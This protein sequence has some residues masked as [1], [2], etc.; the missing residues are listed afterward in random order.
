MPTASLQDPA[1][2]L[3]ERASSSATIRNASVMQLPDGPLPPATRETRIATTAEPGAA[4]QAVIANFEHPATLRG[5]TTHFTV[6]YDPALGAA[7]QSL[8]DG[9][10]ARCE[11]D[12]T[13]LAAIFA[14]QVSHF[15]IILANNIG[16]GAYHDNCSASDLYCDASAGATSDS[17]NFLVVA[18]EVEV[19]Q[20]VQNKGWNCGWS[21]GEGLSRTLAT[22]LYPA[23]LKGFTSASNWLNAAG[24]PDYVDSNKQTDT[25]YVSIGCSV[26]FLNYLRSQLGYSWA[27]IAQAG[28]ATLNEIYKNLTRSQNGFAEFSAI[29]QARFPAGTP[30]SVPNDNPFPLAAVSV[31][32]TLIDTAQNAPGGA[33]FN[34]LTYMAWAGTDSNHHLN[35]MA[36]AHPAVWVNKTTLS[37]IS[38]TGC[39]LCVFNGRLYIAWQGVDNNQINVMSSPDGTHFGNKVTLSDTCGGRPAM[40]VQAG[41]LALAWT[42]ADSAQHINIMS[43]TDGIHFGNK[44]TLGDTSAGAVSLASFANRLFLAWEGTDN[45]HHLNVMSS[46][47][48]GASWQNK[49]MISEISV[50]QPGLLSSG[51]QLILTWPGTDG[52]HHLNVLRSTDGV[53]FAE[54]ATL[55]ETSNYSPTAA[56]AYGAPAIFWTGTDSHLNV[57][58][59]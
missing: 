16:G 49:V 41:Q 6:Y 55:G 19:F 11:A 26:L 35:I 25:D 3:D 40:T 8:A 38:G 33:T 45:P 46:G 4:A 54:K 22:L 21:N 24:R 27:Q 57:L 30:A 28:G 29:L 51:N 14:V 23:Q 42:G 39:S 7:G 50:A 58:P 10:I 44:H 9:V 1:V 17:V 5:S 52:S 59:V 37:D 31:T 56:L 34:G 48:L 47:D 13:T 32:N 36:S 2:Q 53:H 12:Y 20:A 43:S 18:E 15:N